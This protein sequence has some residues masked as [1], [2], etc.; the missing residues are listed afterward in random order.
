M[1]MK[2]R[3]GNVSPPRTGRRDL[4]QEVR[5]VR[6]RTVA[7]TVYSACNALD[8]TPKAAWQKSREQV[9]QNEGIRMRQRN[10]MH[11]R[12]PWAPDRVWAVLQFLCAERLFIF[13]SFTPNFALELI[14]ILFWT[15]NYS[16]DIHAL[17]DLP[18]P[19]VCLKHVGFW[20]T[21]VCKIARVRSGQFTN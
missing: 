8:N 20:N 4:N 2:L 10:R 19:K 11:K 1:W 15:F 14:L 3:I 7:W 16:I 12:Q 21:V 18:T 17:A 5:I 6:S 9:S 13:V